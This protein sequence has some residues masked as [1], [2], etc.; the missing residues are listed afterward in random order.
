MLSF[1][2]L[3]VPALLALAPASAVRPRLG[4]A[5]AAVLCGVSALALLAWL[6]FIATPDLLV[7]PLGVPWVGM[8]LALDP[9]SAWFALIWAVCGTLASLGALGLAAHDNADL[10]RAEKFMP[11]FLAAMLLTLLAADAFTLLLGF[12]AMSLASWALVVADHTKSEKREAGKLYLVMAAFAGACLLPAFGLLA[13]REGALAFSAMRAAP[14]EGLAASAV[15]ALTLLGAGAKAGLFPLHLWLPVAHPAAPAPA[16]ALMSGAMTKVALYVMARLLFDLSGTAQPWWWGVALIALGVASAAMGV[17]R[18]LLESEIKVILACS[19]I[20]NVG[21]IAV[22]FGLALVFRGSDLGPLAAL[23]LAAALLHAASHAIAKT[24]MFLVAGQVLATTGT[25]RLD[26]LGGLLT[27]MPRAGGVA[28]V[29]ALTLA[30]LPPFALFA[31]EWLMLQALLAVPR[32]GDMALSIGIAA[33][34]LL[35]GLAAAL[36]AVAFVRLFGIAFLSRPRSA[37][38]E[39]ATDAEGLLRSALPAGAL[40]CV[41]VGVLPG[42]LL[43]LLDPALRGLLGSGVARHAGLLAV[44]P[45]RLSDSTTML[46]GLALLLLLALACGGILWALRRHAV[47]GQ[48]VAPGWDCGFNPSTATAAAA[49]Y[50]GASFAQPLARLLGAP[51]FGWRWRVDMPEP[52]EKRAARYEAS[53]RDPAAPALARPVMAGTMAIAV[54][55]NAVTGLTVRRYLS[56][57]FAGLVL[58]LAAVAWLER[59]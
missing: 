5:G 29:G 57:M 1:L 38:A 50:G 53:F 36:S 48:R 18:A 27:R 15:L 13:G 14:P 20:E 21:V 8:H 22:G 6:A 25:G 37:A 34:A 2:A 51:L 30:T 55:V 17:V 10:R 16:S 45:P 56:L 42:A 31:P 23:A 35:L 58:L 33:A 32:I 44:A 4:H 19:T 46:S 54:W 59:T 28:L 12:E 52:G 40:L 49:Q 3:V 7:L 24:T 47:P 26:R 41:L 43:D 9:L 11:L 39:A